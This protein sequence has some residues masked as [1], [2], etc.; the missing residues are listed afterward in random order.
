MCQ[1]HFYY[2]INTILVLLDKAVLFAGIILQ[3]S[4]IFKRS[5]FLPYIVM[6]PG[7]IFMYVNLKS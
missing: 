6:P 4:E 2:I 1:T 7:F 3:K 5:E